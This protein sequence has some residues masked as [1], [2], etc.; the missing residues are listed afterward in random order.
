MSTDVIFITFVACCRGKIEISIRHACI[1]K[2]SERDVAHVVARGKVQLYIF[3][4]QFSEATRHICTE[5]PN[6]FKIFLL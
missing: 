4:K 5:C 6:K 3:P 1:L 2:T